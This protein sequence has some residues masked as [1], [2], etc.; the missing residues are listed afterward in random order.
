MT[1]FSNIF[2]LKDAYFIVAML[3]YKELNEKENVKNT[4]EIVSIL[5]NEN[6]KIEV[7]L[8]NK[9][10]MLKSVDLEFNKKWTIKSLPSGEY[11]LKTK[12][13][14]FFNFSFQ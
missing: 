8:Y 10:V 7:A 14:T 12:E 3:S 5:K 13:K 2:S 9:E 4:L 1:I 11:S 6:H